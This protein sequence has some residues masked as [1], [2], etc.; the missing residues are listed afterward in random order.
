MKGSACA[1]ALSDSDVDARRRVPSRKP[2]AK[3]RQHG[4]SLSRNSLPLARQMKA[5]AIARLLY[6]VCDVPLALC[7]KQVFGNPLLTAV[8]GLHAHSRQRPTG[9]TQR[10]DGNH[11][12]FSETMGWR[13]AR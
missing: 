3:V 6:P 7:Q 4:S 2:G 11:N 10:H 5:I 13:T 1:R 12:S 9:G 8:V